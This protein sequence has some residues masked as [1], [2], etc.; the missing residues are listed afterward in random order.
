MGNGIPV[1]GM[2][3][4][5]AEGPGQLF[6]VFDKVEQRVDDVD[7]STR[8]RECIGVWL[9]DNEEL[10]GVFIARLSH[11]RN[12]VCYWSQA[13]VKRGGLYNFPF[14]FQFVIRREPKLGFLIGDGLR[15]RRL[16]CT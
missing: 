1:D 12:R 4:L 11:P 7:V 5:M 13:I 10:K 16:T 9:V 14:S 8:R 6:G 3:D 2:R 15:D